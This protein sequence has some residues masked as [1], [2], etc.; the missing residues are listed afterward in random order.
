KMEANNDTQQD[1]FVDEFVWPFMIPLFKKGNYAI[2][3]D[4]LGHILVMVVT[5]VVGKKCLELGVLG[6]AK[7]AFYSTLGLFL[8]V[9]ESTLLAHSLWLEDIFSH[10]TIWRLHL[11]L[12][13]LSLW[14]GMVGI[15]SKSVSKARA[16]RLDKETGFRNFSS[17]HGLCGLLGYLFLLATLATGLALVHVDFMELRLCHRF[18]GMVSM[19][20]LACSMWFSFNTGFARREWDP[21]SVVMIKIVTLAASITACGSELGR[22]LRTVVGLMPPEFYVFVQM[23]VNSEWG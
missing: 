1:V 12:G 22:I 2:V 3:F 17:K 14:P 9:G 15:L 21:R 23:S 8:C 16:Y 5:A 7:H 10:D 19:L 11:G 13:I 18:V 6:T 4:V 20:C